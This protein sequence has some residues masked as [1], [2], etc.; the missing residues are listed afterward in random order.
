[1][2]DPH[3]PRSLDVLAISAMMAGASAALWALHAA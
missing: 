3:E 1:M 2:N